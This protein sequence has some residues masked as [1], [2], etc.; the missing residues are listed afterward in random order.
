MFVEQKIK[1]KPTDEKSR[2]L[3]KEI[4]NLSSV[5]EVDLLYHVV[6]NIIAI[7]LL[8]NLILD[9]LLFHDINIIVKVQ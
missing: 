8:I 6:A 9:H 7:F 1:R 2:K 5:T 4:T 3:A